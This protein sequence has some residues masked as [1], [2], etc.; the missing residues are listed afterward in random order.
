MR[1][2]HRAFVIDARSLAALRIALGLLLLVDLADRARDLSAHYTDQGVF[3]RAALI[4]D[5]AAQAA[6]D[7]GVAAWSL[8]LMA[9]DRW[10]Q[11]ALFLAAGWFAGWLLIG[12]RTRLAT[13]AC[14]LLTVSL[15]NR[16]PLV[17]DAGDVVLKCLLFWSMFLP[18]GAAAS[19]DRRLAPRGLLDGSP[20]RFVSVPTA[21]LLLQV[22][23]I[24][25][26]TAAE[27]HSEIWHPDYTALFYTFSIDIFATPLGHWLL[28]YPTLLYWLT[29]AAYWLEWLGP[30]VALVPLGRGWPR[31]CAVCCIWGLHLATAVTMHLGLLP[32]ISM[33]A[34]LPFLPGMFWEGLAKLR[35]RPASDTPATE[36]RP[37]TDGWLSRVFRHPAAVSAPLGR[38]TIAV[39][40]VL[41]AYVAAWNINETTRLFETRLRLPAG[42]KNAARI[43]GLEQTWRMFAP[44]PMTNDGWFCISGLLENGEVV[45]LWQPDAPLPT[46]KPRSVAATYANHR[47][48]QYLIAVTNERWSGE[49]SPFAAWLRRRWNAEFAS[50]DGRRRVK[51]VRIVYYL[52]ETLGPERRSTLVTPLLLYDS[53][54]QGK[55]YSRTPIP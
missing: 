6:G 29:A 47:W 15:Q 44:F 20:R 46:R 38:L 8:H 17:T 4:A 27:K 21:A 12:Y 26:S 39:V 24:Y 11:A 41:L 34:W 51:E 13:V 23:M 5:D 35:R 42:W 2:L 33:A 55:I 14:Y 28:R 36:V 45:N 49:I 53:A 32:W 30:A 18:L 40:A 25:W 22:A 37:H 50:G 1:F 9:G 7:R 19:V 3:P 48:R 52:E 43:T 16:N 54:A 31:L 10:S